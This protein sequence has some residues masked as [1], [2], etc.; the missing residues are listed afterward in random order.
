M[1]QS[2]YI[3]IRLG[4]GAVWL[5][6]LLMISKSATAQI[7]AAEYYVDTDNG[8]GSNTAI[9]SPVDGAWDENSEEVSIN[10]DAGVLSIGQHVVYVR[11]QDNS[12]TW[13]TP[14]GTVFR[15]SDAQEIVFEI[16]EAEYFINSDPGPGNGV[17]F[18][19]TSDGGFGDFLETVTSEVD[20][21]G[22]TLNEGRNE[23]FV[24]FKD[25]NGQWGDA[26]GQTFI[27]SDQAVQEF[28]ISGAEYFIDSDVAPGS[29]TAIAAP[30]D[31]AWDEKVEELNLDIDLP[32]LSEGRHTIFTRF[33]KSNGSWGAKRGFTFTVQD[34]E[35]EALTI[36]GAEYFVNDDPGVG[37]GDP[38]PAPIDGAFDEAIEELEASFNVDGL[39]VGL[40]FVYFRV[41]GSNGKWGPARG[42]PFR[43]EDI[44]FIDQAEYFF[45]SDPGQGNG[46]PITVSKDG[47]FD[48]DF[49]EIDLDIDMSTT[50]LEVGLHTMYIRFKNSKGE[51]SNPS[52]RQITVET[53]PSIAISVD[54]LQF[55]SIVEGD[56]LT[57]TFTVMNEGDAELNITNITSNL[58]DF[59]ISPTTGSIDANSSDQLTFTVKYK[60]VSA[61]SKNGIISILN[62]DRTETIRVLGNA[63]AREP[64]MDISVTE[65]DF[66]TVLVGDSVAQ[67][68]AIYNTGYDV[69]NLSNISV[70]SDEFRVSPNTG[71]LNEG[72]TLTDSL[73]INVAIVPTTEGSKSATL[74][75]GGNVPTQQ[76]SLAANAVLNPEPTISLSSD[77]IAF[78]SVEIDESKQITLELRNLGTNTLE[79]T[80]FNISGSAFSGSLDL[81]ANIERGTPLQVPI[82]FTPSSASSFSGGIEIV[83]NDASNSTVNVVL[84]GEGTVG[85]PEKILTVNPDSLDFGL[86]TVNETTKQSITLINSG[87]ATL[88]VTGINSDNSSFFVENAPTSQNPIFIAAESSEDIDISFAPSQGGETLFT[89]TLAISSDRTDSNNPLTIKVRGTGVDQPT[90]NIQ[91][92]TR[93]LDFGELKLGESDTKTFEITNGGN[94]DLNVTDIFTNETDFTILSPSN[95]TFVLTPGAT[96]DIVVQFEPTEVRVFTNLLS[97][98]NS[99][100]IGTEQLDL[101]GRGVTLST[102]VD[103]TETRTEDVVVNS[104]DAIP[105][106]ISP[107]GLGNNG[108]VFVYYKSG[109]GGTVSSYTK[110]SMLA[111]A[112]GTYSLS[113]P[114]NIS[115]S[116]GVSYWF[117]VSD[118]TNTV[119]SPEVNPNLNPYTISV[120]VAD[121]IVRTA[122]QPAGSEQNFYRLISVPL[123]DGSNTVSSVL[124]NFGEAG[125]ENWRLFRWQ[126]GSYVEH[127]EGGFEGFAPGRGYWF[128]TSSVGSI[129]TGS[130]QSA[131]TDENFSIFLQPGWNMIGSPFTYDTDWS[132]AVIPSTV[133]NLWGYDGSGFTNITTL[134]PWE[135]YFINNSSNNPEELL[136]SPI[137][138]GGGSAKEVSSLPFEHEG[139]WGIQLKAKS[140]L[141]EDNYNFIGSTDL[142]EDQK[143][144]LD[145]VNAPNQPGEFLSLGIINDNV[146]FKKLSVDARKPNLEGHVWDFEI[147]SNSSDEY[148]RIEAL[149]NGELPSNFKLVAFDKDQQTVWPLDPTQ[150]NNKTIRSGI[151]AEIKR[152]FR[153]VAGTEGFIAEHNLGIKDIPSVFELK[154]NYPNPFNPSTTI[155]FGLPEASVVTIEVFNTLGQKVATLIN[156]EME[157]GY[158]DFIW[159]ASR[160]ASGVYFYRMNAKSL[161]SDTRFSQIQKMT[162]VK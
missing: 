79:V 21:S 71:S 147:L 18:T 120:E 44:V 86:V 1:V 9:S 155:V 139:A 72:V 102:G 55:D 118:G 91:L 38:L 114:A 109:G 73:V 127:S 158:H 13:G 19:T 92:S 151:G 145:Q 83:S 149:L 115:T 65:V 60:P 26:R 41:Q 76:I 3:K 45:D 160:V 97:I 2:K 62:N 59:T 111:G 150:I 15:V 119:T 23:I 7:A 88:K 136:L 95:K 152:S 129:Q 135:G 8:E 100:N 105:I 36:I 148:I 89:G 157:A 32:G 27:A 153:I 84:S 140:G 80:S 134:K 14:K 37:N 133:D 53:R 66:G 28:T 17:A 126:S 47:N 29:G 68:F 82:T 52:S 46:T 138:S 122:P 156:N 112:G 107:T 162:L 94:A 144:G 61:G 123:V 48:S 58:P 31:G 116:N 101:L 87:N 69:L 30:A 4:I 143:D 10:L 99:D 54:T 56:S 77:S 161:N 131:P 128:I 67:Q 39:G 51:W 108:S 96:R 34:G 121:G 75:I 110:E 40:H 103:S 63:I 25:V 6:L 93:Q 24:R 106:N 104:G 20:L 35:E 130:G 57:Q 70:N 33:Q 12:G 125:I 132:N 22:V 141:V 11:F 81:P 5:L 113:L 85:P 154:N 117:E 90:P 146:H 159:D 16:T 49:E 42:I 98:T 74:S 50:G 64:I 43:V 78:G 124:S 142:A 137:V